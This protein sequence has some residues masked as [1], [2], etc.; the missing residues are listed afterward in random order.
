MI[1][2]TL[3]KFKKYHPTIVGSD[4]SKYE[5]DI[6]DANLWIKR[7]LLG[8]SLYDHVDDSS[9]D[10]TL[11]SLCEAV[12]ARKAYMEGIPSYDVTETASGF[13]VARNENQA[14]ASPE[15]VAKLVKSMESKL[16][17]SI[18]DLLEYLEDNSTEDGSGPGDYGSLWRGSLT[19]TFLSD[20]FIPTIRMFRRYAPFPESRMEWV[21]QKPRMINVIKLKM[22]PV[23]SQ[24]LCEEIIEEIRDNDLTTANAAIIENIRHAYA[25]LITGDPEE[26]HSYLL[27][28][29]KYIMAHLSDYPAFA[30]SDLYAT[31]QATII[32]KNTI[33]KPIFR[34]GF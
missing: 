8:E 18:E 24:E 20:T 30:D 13:V 16:S 14:P 15:R 21:A 10:Q 2:S 26:G 1:C 33:L 29:K 32:E 12:V 5:S 7:E 34:A 4:Y 11:I 23:L 28:V 6:V 22:Y 25:N 27:R 31:I 9:E 19:Y 3:E 17:N